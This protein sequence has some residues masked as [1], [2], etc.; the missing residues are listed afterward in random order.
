MDYDADVTMPSGFIYIFRDLS[1]L[2]ENVRIDV[3]KEGMQ[4]ASTSEP[5]NA[6]ALLKQMESARELF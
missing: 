5:A 3:S 2:G 1:Q 6:S 4:F